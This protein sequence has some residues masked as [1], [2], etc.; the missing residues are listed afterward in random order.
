M[1]HKALSLIAMDDGPPAANIYR[2]A[3]STSSHPVFSTLNGPPATNG[4]VAMSVAFDFNPKTTSRA[5]FNVSSVDGPSADIEENHALR[6]EINS[7]RS[8][9]YDLSLEC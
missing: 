7:R 5:T 2:S 3:A 9:R 6:N 8:K 4:D 1:R